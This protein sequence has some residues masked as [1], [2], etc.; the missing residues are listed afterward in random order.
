MQSFGRLPPASILV[1]S[2][3]DDL[4]ESSA[5]R[6]SPMFTLVKPVIGGILRRL[7]DRS[8]VLASVVEDLPYTENRVELVSGP[9]RGGGVRLAINYRIRPYDAARIRA[10]RLRMKKALHPLRYR[11]IKQA[12]NNQRLAHACGT[13]RFGVDPRESVLNGDNRA[14]D[15]TNLFVVD[16]SFCPSSAGTNP[17]LTIAANALRVAATIHANGA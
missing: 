5:G 8:L 17:A 6:L 7:V 10:L 4:R 15:I 11:L 3:H 1:E 13:C 9:D 14:H 2:L 16:S 12:E